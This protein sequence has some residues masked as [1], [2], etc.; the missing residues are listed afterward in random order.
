MA[1]RSRLATTGA[2]MLVEPVMGMTG[3]YTWA[4]HSVAPHFAFQDPGSGN[5]LHSACNSNGTAIFPTDEPHTFPLQVRPRAATP[6]GVRGWWED[7]LGTPVASLFYQSTDG[8]LINAFFNCNYETGDYEIDE[9]GEYSISEE[10]GAPSVHE[11][12]GLSV[13]ELGDAGGFRVFYHDADSR[14]NLIAYDDDTDWVYLGPVSTKSATGMSVGSALTSGTSVSVIFPHEEENLA[15]AEF[16]ETARNR[17]TI[18]SLPTPFVGTPPTNQTSASDMTLDDSED[19]PFA[20]PSFDAGSTHLALAADSNTVTSLFYIG[21][22]RRLHQIHQLNG[23]WEIAEDQQDEW[24]EADDESARLAIVSEQWSGE[25]WLYYR[26][27]GNITELYQDEFGSWAEPRVTLTRN[28]TAPAPGFNDEN[29]DEGNGTD[30]G[31]STGARAGIGIG[32]TAAVLAAIAVGFFF[33]RRRRRLAYES[34]S[35]SSNPAELHD[36][37]VFSGLRSFYPLNRNRGERGPWSDEAHKNDAMELNPT[38]AP[39]ELDAMPKYELAAD[40]ELGPRRT[41]GY[42]SPDLPK[43]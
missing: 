3:W 38:P 19:A 42:V 11:R 27:G 14:V 28:E 34:K 20:L 35:P 18:S 40:G 13:E 16:N 26:S 29:E 10:A 22:D 36:A 4:P 32:V 17:W 12:T 6:L 33:L 23:N 31:L 7:D 15:L 1:R 8:S 25:V 21:T 2:L 5:I 30:E 37:S 41:D 9:D 39:Q 43:R 24:P